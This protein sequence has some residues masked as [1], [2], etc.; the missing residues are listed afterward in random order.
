MKLSK[1]TWRFKREND[2]IIIVIGE[3]N[4]LETEKFL[5]VDLNNIITVAKIHNG[6]LIQDEYAINYKG[7]QNKKIYITMAIKFE[8]TME[9]VDFMNFLEL[10]FI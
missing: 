9:R 3:G 5:W 6:K 7:E 4:D 2:F 1:I 8:T 10:N